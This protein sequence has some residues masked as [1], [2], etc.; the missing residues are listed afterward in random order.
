MGF[1]YTLAG[2]PMIIFGN[3]QIRIIGIFKF[4]GPAFRSSP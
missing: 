2:I 1:I 3:H 4:W